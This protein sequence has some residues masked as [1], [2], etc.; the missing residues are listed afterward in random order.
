MRR[1]THDEKMLIGTYLDQGCTVSGIA[2]K[3]GR[4]EGTV[5]SFVHSWRFIE[6]YCMVRRRGKRRKR[7]GYQGV[8][9]C[10]TFC[11]ARLDFDTDGSGSLL[12][13]CPKHGYAA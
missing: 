13:Y 3:M 10:C 11:G 5:W 9:G 6:R 7:R 8:D 4:P 2:V 12:E 1:L